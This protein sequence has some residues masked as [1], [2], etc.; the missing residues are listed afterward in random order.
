M[1]EVADS[2][3][4]VTHKTSAAPRD[5]RLLMPSEPWF[6]AFAQNLRDL[7]VD[8]FT[9]TGRSAPSRYLQSTPGNFWPDVFVDRQLPWRRFLESGGYHLLA[10]IAILGGLRFPALQPHAAPQSQFTHADVVY[11]SAADYLPPLDTR[12]DTSRVHS[13]RA[14]KADPEI[15]RQPVISV[16]KEA[17]NRSQTIVAPPRVQLKHDLALPNSVSFSDK[18]RMPIA[19]APLVPASQVTRLAPQLQHTVIAPP[20]QITREARNKMRAPEQSVVAPPPDLEA[21]SERRV[22]DLNIANS[23]VI[24]PAPQLT[25]DA[26]R[27]LSQRAQSPRGSAPQVIAP[28]PA[29][30]A[31]G[32]ARSG[33]N[34]VA[35]SLHPAVGAPPEAS[36]GNR[37][38]TFAATPEGHRGAS[39]LPGSA[40]DVSASGAS[41]GKATE[42]KL[43]SGLYV[44]EKPGGNTVNPKLI[45]NAKPPRIGGPD[46]PSSANPSSTNLAPVERE[47]FGSRRIYSLSLNMPNLNS[48]GGSWII[49]FTPLKPEA[50]PAAASGTAPSGNLSSPVATRKVDPAYPLELMKQN[51]QGTVILYGVIRADGTVGAVRVLQSVD[52]RLDRFASEAIAKWQFQPATKDGSPVDVE[53]TFWIPFR[54][55]RVR[56]DF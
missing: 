31:L 8:G 34:M 7:L 10:L 54:A 33:G 47:V 37:R 46:R 48:A 20:P 39:G 23:A 30:G 38:G 5:L 25:L 14:Q 12:R 28:P 17:D 36:S 21:A 45:A 40:G 41:A 53:A 1:P 4:P 19:P 32:R 11:Y 18:P 49:R 42:S 44:G 35:L 6:R 50:G 52:E 9:R 15:S 56:P 22:G 51:V 55:A 16:P 27:T 3:I 24:A 29:L 43:P 26:Q 2:P 13:S